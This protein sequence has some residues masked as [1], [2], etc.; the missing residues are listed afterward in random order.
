MLHVRNSKWNLKIDHLTGRCSLLIY[1]SNNCILTIY[2]TILT[3]KVLISSSMHTSVEIEKMIPIYW[4]QL[5]YIIASN[6]V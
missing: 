4:R 3:K 5:D 6:S 2:K 1:R